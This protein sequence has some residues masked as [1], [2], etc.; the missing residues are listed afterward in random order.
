MQQNISNIIPIITTPPTKKQ[1]NRQFITK[2]EKHVEILK[3]KILIPSRPR[4]DYCIE[5]TNEKHT[6][7]TLTCNSYTQNPITSVTNGTPSSYSFPQESHTVVPHDPKKFTLPTLHKL[8][9]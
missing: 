9:P 1:P 6:C 8:V 5:P 3:T 2:T 7:K 4:T